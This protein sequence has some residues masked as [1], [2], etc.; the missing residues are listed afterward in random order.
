MKKQVVLI[1]LVWLNLASLQSPAFADR[2]N[3]SRKHNR[4][5][6]KCWNKTHGH[7]MS[8]RQRHEACGKY[9]KNRDGHWRAEDTRRY[10]Q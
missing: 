5:H 10:H 6:D 2:D 8:D 7:P 1:A 3:W 9:D 4:D